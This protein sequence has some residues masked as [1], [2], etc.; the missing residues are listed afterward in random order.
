MIT[1][2]QERA[3][4]AVLTAAA[5]SAGKREAA[6][7]RQAAA[8]AAALR[9]RASH[10]MEGLRAVCGALMRCIAAM[11]A[12]SQRLRPS[13]A[14]GPGSSQGLAAAPTSARMSPQTPPP[15]AAL[16]GADAIA[17][18]T[19]LSLDEVNDLL[20]VGAMLSQAASN[21]TS[22]AAGAL[23]GGRA[24]SGHHGHGAGAA[25]AGS[26]AVDGAVG[27]MYGG[28]AGGGV[29]ALGGPGGS[30]AE[31]AQ[32]V[33]DLLLALEATLLADLSELPAGTAVRG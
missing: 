26:S 3:Q 10:L 5:E 14:S 11:E 1:V 6:A 19:S 24:R 17:A 28:G 16:L 29:S 22:A 7:W 20:H 13:A 27:N 30:A 21:A 12:A 32:R 33:G 23:S 15:A 4:L 8:E 31:A 18:M 2:V 25:T 9:G